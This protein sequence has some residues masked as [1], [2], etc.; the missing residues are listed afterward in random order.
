MEVANN[1]HINNF[2]KG[3]L[4]VF[5]HYNEAV[6]VQYL[7]SHMGELKTINIYIIND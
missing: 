5:N 6:W 7:C 2:Y 3:F 4:H 1:L